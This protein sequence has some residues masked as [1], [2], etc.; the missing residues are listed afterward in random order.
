MPFIDKIDIV[1]AYVGRK[2]RTFTIQWEEKSDMSSWWTY[3]DDA[4]WLTAGSSEFDK[5]FWYYW[6]RLSSAWVE[7]DKV[8]QSTPWILD[9]TQLWTLTSWDNVMI[10]FP[11]RWIKMS[12][13]GSMVTLSI[14]EEPNKEWYQYYAHTKWSAD[15]DI[16]YL[17]AYKMSS[18]Y[19]SL[20]WLAPLVNQTRATF[21]SWVKSAYDSLAWTN[22]Y[23]QITIYPRWYINALYM[24]KYGNPNSQSVIWVGYTW[25]S[26]AV[27]TWW[28]NSQT[29]ATYWTSSWTVQC[30]LFWLE[31]WYWNVF[32]WNDGCMFNSSTNLTVDK[33]NSV[34][35]DSDYATNLWA[36]SKWWLAWID[37]S[38][39]WMFKNVNI[40]WWSA[41]TYYCDVFNW[42][43]GT[44]VL[45]LWWHWAG[46]TDAGINY[47]TYTWTSVAANNIGSRLQYL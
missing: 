13:S 7:T 47:L 12:K 3:L 19:K 10:A 35:Q 38:N 1:D 9:I 45:L 18:W 17:W 30:K 27:N 29:N 39:D 32:E 8:E 41:T 31:D 20:S 42:W 24:M 26:A 16:L 2:E 25:W 34:F 6:C 36:T 46:W 43:N 11:R 33:T 21:R 37:W 5:F 28:T 44:Y 40:S 14:T 15:K 22:R 4:S 23:S